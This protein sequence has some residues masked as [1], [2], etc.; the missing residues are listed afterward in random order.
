MSERGE[1]VTLMDSAQD[2]DRRLAC[3]NSHVDNNRGKLE[4]LR[5]KSMR[6]SRGA[7]QNKS[8]VSHFVH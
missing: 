6:R 2:S 3:G 8:P 5:D 7:Q 4:L 1:G